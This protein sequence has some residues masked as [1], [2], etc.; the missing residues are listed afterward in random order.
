MKEYVLTISNSGKIEG[1]QGIAL[2]QYEHRVT[3]FA[4]NISA[5]VENYQQD[6][7]LLR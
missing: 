6:V 4:I 5:F 1:I 3:R 7:L 2:M